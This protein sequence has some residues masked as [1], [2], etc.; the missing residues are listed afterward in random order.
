[1]PDPHTARLD[2]GTDPHDEASHAKFS[3]K[4]YINDLIFDELVSFVG[5]NEKKPF[6]LMWAAPLPHV[7]LQAPEKWVKHYVEK[8]GGEVPYTGKAGYISCRH[9]YATYVAMISYFGEQIGRLIEKLK[10]DHLYDNTIIT[11][12]SDNGPTFN[13]GSDSP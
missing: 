2:P 6:F 4:G 1:M 12:T 7:P 9:P 5:Q 11:F 3:Q 10:T 8:L 13:G